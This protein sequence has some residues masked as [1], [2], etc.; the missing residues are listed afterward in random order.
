M[1]QNTKS[2]KNIYIRIVSL[3]NRKSCPKCS[4]KLGENLIYSSGIYHNGNW[5]TVYHFCMSCFK[6]IKPNFQHETINF[7]GYQGIKIPDWLKL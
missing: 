6:S 1:S 5:K 4:S 3:G 7:I 2:V